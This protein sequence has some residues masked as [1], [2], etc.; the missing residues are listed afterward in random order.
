MLCG[1]DAEEHMTPTIENRWKE[2]SRQT[3]HLKK[4]A[5]ESMLISERGNSKGQWDK[6][7]KKKMLVVIRRPQIG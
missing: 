2:T 4:K 3:P 1:R 6:G 5:G 7:T